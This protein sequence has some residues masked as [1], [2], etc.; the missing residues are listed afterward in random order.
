MTPYPEFLRDLADSLDGCE[1]YHPL[2]SAAR[3]REA[4]G[5]M[6]RLATER[7]VLR[8]LLGRCVWEC[9]WKPRHNHLVLAI[10][11]HVDAARKESEVRD[12]PT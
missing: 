11:P 9:D 2:M 1:W 8:R 7:D 12:E 6:E 10:K 4:A 3:C 5:E